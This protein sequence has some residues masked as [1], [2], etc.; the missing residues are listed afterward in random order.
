[1]KISKVLITDDNKNEILKK[2]I[3]NLIKSCIIKWIQNTHS[4]NNINIKIQINYD[5]SKILGLVDLN[6][7]NNKLFKS[8]DYKEFKQIEFV[9]DENDNTECYYALLYHIISNTFINTGEFNIDELKKHIIDNYLYTDNY[10]DNYLNMI[11]LILT[12]T[13]NL[14][15]CEYKDDKDDKIIGISLQIESD[16][17][18]II[19]FTTILEEFQSESDILATIYKTHNLLEFCIHNPHHLHD[20]SI[21]YDNKEFI[22]N[23][24]TS[25]YQTII[26]RYIPNAKIKCYKTKQK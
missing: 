5:K 17:K 19:L 9:N 25:D 1:M 16:G 3:Y 8:T 11:D 24:T 13:D 6:D 20:A 2:L 21:D 15:Y 23:N 22:L 26:N 12:K 10:A 14:Y 7:A 18:N 4:I